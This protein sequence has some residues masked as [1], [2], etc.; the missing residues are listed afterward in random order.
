MS[1]NRFITFDPK[2]I[3]KGRFSFTCKCKEK[4][5]LVSFYGSTFACNFWTDQPILLNY[6]SDIYD[7][8]TRFRAPYC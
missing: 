1:W 6:T 5:S 8:D 2:A 4:T 7:Y 3:A